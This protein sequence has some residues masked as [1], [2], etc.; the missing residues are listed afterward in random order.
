MI[1]AQQQLNISQAIAYKV[2]CTEKGQL[3]GYWLDIFGKKI[4][5]QEYTAAKNSNDEFKLNR[6][7]KTLTDRYDEAIKSVK[8]G[9]VYYVTEL[10]DNYSYDFSSSSVK[11]S[12]SKTNK[13]EFLDVYTEGGVST[14]WYTKGLQSDLNPEFRISNTDNIP[15]LFEMPVDIAEKSFAERKGAN[16]PAFKV[17]Y[18]FKFWQCGSEFVK[19]NYGVFNYDVEVVKVEL[20]DDIVNYKKAYD[21]TPGLQPY[22]SQS[23]P[24]AENNNS[25]TNSNSSS[26]NQE[27]S[28]EEKNVDTVNKSNFSG[29]FDAGFYKSEYKCFDNKLFYK[30]INSTITSVAFSGTTNNSKSYDLKVK[31]KDDLIA[32]IIIDGFKKYKG[33]FYSI[34]SVCTTLE[35]GDKVESKERKS[36]DSNGETFVFRIHY[37]P[38]LLPSNVNSKVY[39]INFMIY[40]LFNENAS[41][42]GFYK[43]TVVR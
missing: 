37:T 3:K 24:T 19:E 34:Y 29:Y 7:K 31:E 10:I 13:S 15:R 42:Q 21:I 20:I 9:S 5:N 32:D 12:F 43:F 28:S 11:I 16:R 40:D 23:S 26:T 6:I 35:N 1:Y 17:R 25:N 18:Y 33:K 36:Y 38:P 27:N 8:I 39:Y 2:A 41:I 30:S 14:N 4:M 22:S